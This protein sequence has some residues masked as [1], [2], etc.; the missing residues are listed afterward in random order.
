MADSKQEPAVKHTDEEWKQKLTSE[1][2]EICRL[3]NT[4]APF[5][6]ALYENKEPGMYKCVACGEQLFGSEA[7]YESGSGWPSFYDAVSN[8][9]IK[10]VDDYSHGMY[11]KE[12][13][14]ANCHSHLG[15]LF[16]DGPKPTGL[17]YC[18]NSVALA[19]EPKQK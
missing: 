8:E 6:G 11:R 13:Q 5:T 3:G 7:K 14:C 19:F 2:F 12:V 4:E 1:Q 9:K 17:R 15:H 18:I 10:L 16:E